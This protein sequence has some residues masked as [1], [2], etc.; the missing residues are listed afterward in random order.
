MAN[1]PQLQLSCSLAL[2]I[3]A[4]AVSSV[5]NATVQAATLCNHFKSD[6][7]PAQNRYLQGA[8]YQ[9]TVATS[10]IHCVR[11][12]HADPGCLSVN[13]NTLKR[14]CEL[15]N[16]SR[17]NSPDN[18]VTLYGS[19]Y[20]DANEDTPLHSITSR[21]T[22][23]MELLEE[24]HTANGIYTIFPAPFGIDGL[25]VYCDMNTA[26]GG[27]MVIQRRQDGSVDFFRNWTE[28]QEGFGSLSGEFWFGNEN[29]RS[30]TRAGT[31][32]L[33][34]DLQDWDNERVYAE[35]GAFRVSGDN[36]QLTVGSYNDNSTAGDAMTS[37]HN[38]KLFSTKD[39]DND[40]HPAGSC[41]EEDHGAW[42][43][44]W[45][46]QANLNGKFYGRRVIEL[47]SIRW[48]PWKKPQSVKKASMK[49]RKASK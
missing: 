24:G 37:M 33:R 40:M 41:A 25:Q 35:Y 48:T 2:V 47:N 5:T 11:D 16:L 19:V 23:C 17:G 26:D 7:L 12:C 20:F 9:E 28:Y 45:C 32:Q 43:Y 4:F 29:L 27:W 39:K 15:R 10:H 8:S 38:G 21:Y 46:Y 34:V 14:T 42:W 22:S 36:Y 44:N 30:L 6:F 3:L 18:L 13:Y 1:R 49:I 31:W